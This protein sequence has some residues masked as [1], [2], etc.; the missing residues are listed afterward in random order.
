MTQSNT[1]AVHFDRALMATTSDY[2]RGFLD[3]GLGMCDRLEQDFEQM[4]ALAEDP[5]VHGLVVHMNRVIAERRRMFKLDVADM[6]EK[7]RTDHGRTQ[8][9]GKDVKGSGDGA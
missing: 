5:R 2:E 3:G 4:G 7:R 8:D 1:S 6:L 9:T